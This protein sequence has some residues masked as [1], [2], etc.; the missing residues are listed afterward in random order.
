MSFSGEHMLTDCTHCGATFRVTPAQLG[1][2]GGRV[3]C[4]LC[5]Q[6]FD[7]FVRLRSEPEAPAPVSPAAAPPAE[8]KLADPTAD[9][10]A[11][12]A[13]KDAQSP[14][15]SPPDPEPAIAGPGHDLPTPEA[16][17]PSPATDAPVAPPPH[18]DDDLAVTFDAVDTAA[19]DATLTNVEIPTDLPPVEPA[20]TTGEE[21]LTAI[22]QAVADDS[23]ER[24]ILEDTLTDIE[25]PTELLE[26]TVV[27]DPGAPGPAGEAPD[28]SMP[29][30]ASGE[31]D[32]IPLAG[33]PEITNEAP[34]SDAPR[35]P[36]ETPPSQGDTEIIPGFPGF[37]PPPPGNPSEAIPPPTEKPSTSRAS[38][39]A[40]TAGALALGLLL[41]VQAAFVFRD[42]LADRFPA[43]HPMLEGLCRHAGCRVALPR[44]SDKLEIETSDLQA[45]DPTRPN[46][47][48][49][50]ASIR[51]LAPVTQAFPKLELTLTDPADRPVARRVFEPTH[52][53][54]E[55]VAPS[56]GFA[57]R[58][59]VSVRIQLDTGA[60][61][62]SGYRLF[63]FHE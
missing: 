15:S 55:S 1:A 58:T 19:L 60:I 51:N 45:L 7:G 27:D 33:V 28:P 18:A 3:R 46:R 42:A 38:R 22:R 11:R 6:I 49:L 16:A 59:D 44:R 53:L 40:L 63:L 17:T 29:V 4:G 8:S 52:Y 10:T 12:P 48:V 31:T 56:T 39:T 13:S 21:A 34:G 62:A 23:Q 35:P 25:I 41:P 54:P 61:T 5:A 20:D 57:P 32:G 37:V 30:E 50:I 24:A 14:I 36:L 9:A 26:L 47:V 43:L 2:S